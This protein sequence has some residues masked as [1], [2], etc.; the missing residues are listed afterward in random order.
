M[1][2]KIVNERTKYSTLEEEKGSHLQSRIE[3]HHVN[4]DRQDISRAAGIIGLSKRRHDVHSRCR[5][6][7]SSGPESHQNPSIAPIMGLGR[8]VTSQNRACA[9]PEE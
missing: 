3:H 7:I 2:G 4:R 1:K 6:D 5:R 8:G 9:L